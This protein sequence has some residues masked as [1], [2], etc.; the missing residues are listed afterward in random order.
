MFVIDRMQDAF[1]TVFISFSIDLVVS[2]N[3]ND[4]FRLLVIIFMIKFIILQEIT[5]IYYGKIADID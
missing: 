2:T 3:N 4:N 5:E 1:G